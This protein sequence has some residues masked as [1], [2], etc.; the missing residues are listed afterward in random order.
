MRNNKLD[1]YEY[2]SEILSRYLKHF[3]RERKAVC[4]QEGIESLHRMRVASRRLRAA[5]SVFR[6]ILPQENVKKWRHK[7]RRI[8][9]LLGQARQ[10]D[11]QIRFLEKAGRDLKGTSH[12]ANIRIMIRLLEKRRRGIQK[13][14]KPA[15]SAAKMKKQFSWLKYCIDDLKA[16]KDSKA[17]AAFSAHRSSMISK[18][19]NRVFSFRSYVHEPACL[20]ELH[21]LRIA[22]K[23]LRYTLEIFQPWYGA[24][25]DRFIR[26]SRDIQDVLGDFRELDVLVE[27][28]SEVGRLRRQDDSFRETVEHLAGKYAVLRENT[29][30]DFV[31]RWDLTL[32]ARATPPK[33]TASSPS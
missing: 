13:Q 15:L 27:F 3:L 1:L 17:G 14:I 22:A 4:R 25:I 33:I 18:R 11:I 10:L 28:L 5:L 7:I 23:N 19:V 2:A 16:V 32:F 12:T 31:R 21:L 26:S 24:K 8:G 9:R 29:Y 6:D 30:Q 20:K